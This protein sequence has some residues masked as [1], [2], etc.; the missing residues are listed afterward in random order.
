MERDRHQ[1]GAAGGMSAA[2]TAPAAEHALDPFLDLLRCPVSGE[3]LIAMPGALVTADGQHRYRIDEAG[4]PLFADGFLSEAAAVQRLHYNKIAAAYTANLGYPHTQEYMVYLD[5]AMRDA[6]GGGEFGTAAEL[7]CGHGEALRAAGSIRISSMS[8]RTCCRT[9]KAQ[10]R[11]PDALFVRG[12]A[13][14][15]QLGGQERRY[16]GHVGPGYTMCR[17]A[18]ACS[19]RCAILSRAAA[20]IASG[21][22]F[23]RVAG[24]AGDCLPLVADARSRDGAPIVVPRDGSPARTS[25]SAI[26]ALPNPRPLRFLPLHESRCVVF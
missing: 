18:R 17:I 13:T 2:E 15:V 24:D 14:R 10:H 26:A 1:A 22:R 9:V 7:C 6:I 4:I 25:G 5:R 21:Q 19:R 8:R 20:S 12:D 11:H 23:R 3:R 16:R